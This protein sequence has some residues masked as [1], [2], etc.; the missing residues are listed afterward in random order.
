M[1]STFYILFPE[2]TINCNK[3]TSLFNNKLPHL[4]RKRRTKIFHYDIVSEECGYF[5]YFVAIPIG[6]EIYGK[7][8]SWNCREI[9]A[10]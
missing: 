4:W 5:G 3:I 6:I 10:K 8:K 1:L 2:N 9:I 7:E